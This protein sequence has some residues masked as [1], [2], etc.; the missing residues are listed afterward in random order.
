MKPHPMQKMKNVLKVIEELSDPQCVIS[1]VHSGLLAAQAKIVISHHSS[2]IIDA[3][4]LNVPVIHHQ[5]FTEHWLKRHPD[6][7]TQLELGQIRTSNI[8]DL[9]LELEDVEQKKN[10]HSNLIENVKH[11]ECIKNLFDKVGLS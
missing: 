8:V 4:A 3:M 10:I 11:K 9:D 1:F 7:I 5:V 2:T 6:G